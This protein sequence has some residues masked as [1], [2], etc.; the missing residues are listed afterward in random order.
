MHIKLVTLKNV[1]LAYINQQQNG[2]YVRKRKKKEDKAEKFRKRK[3]EEMN[4]DKI[5]NIANE[6]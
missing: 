4:I 5:E 2:E 1:V 3:R 6:T